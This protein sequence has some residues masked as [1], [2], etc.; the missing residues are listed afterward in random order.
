MTAYGGTYKFDGSTI[1]HHIDISWNEVWTGTTQ[2]K[3]VKRDAD[4]LVYTTPRRC[5]R[6]PAR[7]SRSP[8]SNQGYTGE[9]PAGEA[10]AHGIQYGATARIRPLSS[11]NEY[12]TGYRAAAPPRSSRLDKGGR[13]TTPSIAGVT[14][15]ARVLGCMIAQCAH[16]RL[17]DA[18]NRLLQW[19]ERR[20]AAAWATGAGAI[21]SRPYAVAPRARPR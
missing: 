13:P 6:Q 4:R 10:A 12:L 20:A 8:M 7:A 9:V 15:D 5:G 21:V 17:G 16:D 2:V 14:G 1:E 19:S 11:A 18:S 3:S